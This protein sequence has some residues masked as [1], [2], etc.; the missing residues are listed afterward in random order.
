MQSLSR[1]IV[2]DA[3]QTVFT[4]EYF[5]LAG[6]SY[7][8]TTATLGAAWS[9]SSPDAA[10]N[11][12]RTELAYDIRGRLKRTLAPTGTITRTVYDS[13]GRV[14]SIW[15]GTDDMPTSGFWSPTNTA[16]TAA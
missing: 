13:P 7:S 14:S 15:V 1:S 16:G 5:T 4:D 10:A 12:Y 9:F 11:F 6:T 3:G 8:Q 2:N